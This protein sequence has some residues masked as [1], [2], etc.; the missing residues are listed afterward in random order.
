MVGPTGAKIVSLFN[1][2]G[3]LYFV[4]EGTSTKNDDTDFG[5]GN[6]YR[7]NSLIRSLSSD[8]YICYFKSCLVPIFFRL[9][10]NLLRLLL[11]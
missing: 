9:F 10:Q 3:G 8:R 7:S 2:A 11:F 6:I 4:P 1:G 5:L